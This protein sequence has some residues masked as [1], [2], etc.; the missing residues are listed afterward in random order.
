MFY[1]FNGFLLEIKTKSHT[2]VKICKKK[3]KSFYK[4]NL[5]N[6]IES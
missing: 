5:Q 6:V 3:K 4:I 2:N 1:G